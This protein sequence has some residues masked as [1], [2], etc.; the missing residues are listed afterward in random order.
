[1]YEWVRSNPFAFRNGPTDN[2]FS[3][4]GALGFEGVPL[5]L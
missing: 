5:I 1:M 3:R 2:G 4:W